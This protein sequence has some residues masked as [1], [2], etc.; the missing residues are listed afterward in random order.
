MF[1]CLFVGCK[2]NTQESDIS[3]LRKNNELLIQKGL[4]TKPIFIKNVSGTYDDMRFSTGSAIKDALIF[5]DIKA[6]DIPNKLI[7][8]GY[9]PA[10]VSREEAIKLIKN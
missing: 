1:V 8:L 5:G 2:N 6:K 7:N 9:N 4:P 3:K 10:T